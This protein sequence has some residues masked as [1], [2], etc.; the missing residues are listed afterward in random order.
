MNMLVRAIAFAC[1]VA[2]AMPSQAGEPLRI[3]VN[4][5]EPFYFNQGDQWQGLE[6][7]ILAGFAETREAGVEWTN[8]N[9]L[10]DL[11]SSLDQGQCEIG[12]ALLTPTPERSERFD[13]SSP[14]F[15]VRMVLV[16]NGTCEFHGIEELAG[17]R[18][19]TIRGSSYEEKLAQVPEIELVYTKT[20]VEL[21]KTL[22]SGKADALICDSAIV[23]S[24]MQ[25]HPEFAVCGSSPG[26]EVYAFA[27]RKDSPLTADLDLYL[28]Q[29]RGSGA[30]RDL[31]ERYF[32]AKI[33]ELIMGSD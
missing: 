21:G 32:E 16:A 2:G 23:V 12:A 13:F 14:Y 29:L 6:H 15:P 7:D 19:A 20:Y 9:S 4:S 27:L 31:L 28:E 22:A 3:C 11:F 33:V 30:Y 26:Q 10:G 18:V 17:T 8:F 1:L 5:M 24:I 25:R